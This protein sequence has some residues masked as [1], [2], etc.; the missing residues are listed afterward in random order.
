MHLN[1]MVITDL[2]VLFYTLLQEEIAI[3]LPVDPAIS[4]RYNVTITEGNPVFQNLQTA[5]NHYMTSFK[6]IYHA[7]FIIYRVPSIKLLLIVVAMSFMIASDL[8]K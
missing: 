7:G 3:L 6:I 5:R 4:S 2:L 1:K 8:R